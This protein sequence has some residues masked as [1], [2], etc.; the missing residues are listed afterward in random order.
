MLLAPPS[1]ELVT[2]S[3]ESVLAAGDYVQLGDFRLKHSPGQPPRGEV[4]SSFTSFCLFHFLFTAAIAVSNM[5]GKSV[6]INL[7]DTNSSSTATWHF[8]KCPGATDFRSVSVD[9]GGATLCRGYNGFSGIGLD[10]ESG[11]ATVESLQLECESSNG[12][13]VEV[14]DITVYFSESHTAR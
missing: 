6:C 5:V 1:T 11:E 8:I 12:T 7:T 9:T 10:F 3:S 4:V 2:R 13:T 14:I